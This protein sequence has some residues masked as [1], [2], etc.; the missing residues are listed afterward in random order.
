MLCLRVLHVVIGRAVDVQGKL[1]HS[2][3]S[4]CRCRT[5]TQSKW[6]TNRTHHG[7]ECQSLQHT[8]SVMMHRST[9]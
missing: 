5:P 4:F 6:K 7:A 8:S 3:A 9:W 1:L 2:T